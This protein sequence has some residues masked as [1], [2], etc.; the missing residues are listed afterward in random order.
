M[1]DFPSILS[2]LYPVPFP[3]L[4]AKIFFSLFLH[5]NIEF[6]GDNQPFI[7]LKCLMIPTSP[8]PSTEPFYSI[9]DTYGQGEDHCQFVDS[10]RD[11]R[12]GPAYL[13]NNLPSAQGK[14]KQIVHA[15]HICG[16]DILRPILLSFFPCSLVP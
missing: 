13:S 4:S 14:Q 6:F 2:R 11:G 10:Y 1:Y 8:F 15:L 16:C 7:I 12:T 3:A 5:A 9:G